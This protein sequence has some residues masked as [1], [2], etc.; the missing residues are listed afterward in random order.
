VPNWSGTKATR[1]PFSAWASGGSLPWYQAYNT[2][3][4]D[5]HSQFEEATFEHLIDACSGLLVLL[6]AQ[7]ETND[8]TPGNTYLALEGGSDGMESGIGGYFRVRFPAKWPNELRYDFDGQKLKSEADP[9]RN[10]D[11]SKIAEQGLAATASSVRS[12]LALAFGHG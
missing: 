11:Y 7:F 9:F 6:S 12:C 1:L 4:H 2:T 5:R 10:I 8:F 3:K